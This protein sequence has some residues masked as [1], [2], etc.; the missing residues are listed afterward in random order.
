MGDITARSVRSLQSTSQH[1]SCH[2]WRC[3]RL[4]PWIWHHRFCVRHLA[5]NFHSRFRDIRATARKLDYQ[6][7]RVAR[8]NQDAHAWL[9]SIQVD[10]SALC[11]DGGRRYGMM[12]TNFSDVF[13]SVLKG[14][15]NILITVCIQMTFYWVNDYFVLRSRA[16][17]PSICQASFLWKSRP[18]VTMCISYR[19][20]STK[21]VISAWQIAMVS[22][23][24]SHTDQ[25]W[26]YMGWYV[27]VMSSPSCDNSAWSSTGQDHFPPKLQWIDA[28][29]VKIA[30]LII[31]SGRYAM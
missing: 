9:F 12:T 20:R 28:D 26:R 19:Y 2:E 25:H 8:I 5:S 4:G 27:H 22:R 24:E 10:K 7:E 29:V 30:C 31:C 17:A 15:R 16:A 6:M 23:R 18:T 14:V 21:A 11:H 3:S 13:N 1:Y